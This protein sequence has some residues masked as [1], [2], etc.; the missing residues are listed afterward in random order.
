[1]SQRRA[2]SD[3]YAL[4][5]LQAQTGTWYWAVHF[6]R[7]GKLHYRRF[8]E[9]KHGG[10]AGARKAAVAWRDGQLA[11]VE[12]LGK[13]EFC[14]QLRSNNTSGV[15]GV[16]FLV[17]RTQPLGYWQAR[18]KL[19]GQTARYKAFSVRKYGEQRAYKLAVQARQR[20]LAQADN[21]PYLYAE[22][23]RHSLQQGASARAD[24]AGAS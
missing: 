16:H 5:R 4:I 9:P 21:D 18:L 13:L 14:Q 6:K 7:R 20:M 23:A 3:S 10:N 22:L 1:M 17:S 8:Y 15:P 19:A 12:P 2:D 24:G 11:E